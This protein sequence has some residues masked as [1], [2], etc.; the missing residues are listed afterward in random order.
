MLLEPRSCRRSRPSG[1]SVALLLVFALSFG[2]APR[3]AVA[4]AAPP[5]RDAAAPVTADELRAAVAAKDD[6]LL[7]SLV[8]RTRSPWTAVEGFVREGDAEV[9]RAVA[10]AYAGPDAEALRAHAAALQP[11]SAEDDAAVRAAWEALRAARSEA[12]VTSAIE[13]VKA[14]PEPARPTA[15]RIH[16]V[17]DVGDAQLRLDR[18]D[19]AMGTLSAAGENAEEIGWLRGAQNSFGGAAEAAI[20]WRN[21]DGAADAMKRYMVATRGLGVAA[22]IADGEVSLASALVLARR[23]DEARAFAEAGVAAHRALDPKSDGYAAAL[24]TAAGVHRAAGDYELALEGLATARGVFEELR[25]G[26]WVAHCWNEEGRVREDM[27]DRSGALDA[28]L[29]CVELARSRGDDRVLALALSNAVG[30]QRAIGN[31]TAAHELS[32]EALAAA[33]RSGDAQAI[34]AAHRVLGR[35]KT[36]IGAFSEAL[37]HLHEAE[38]HAAKLQFDTDVLDA[39]MATADTLARMGDA[40]G[41]REHLTATLPLAEAG[42][43]P[44]LAL[45]IRLR[46]ASVHVRLDRLAK[47]RTLYA[48]LLESELPPSSH[49]A[50]LLNAAGVHLRLGEADRG[51][52][53]MLEAVEDML[54]RDVAELHLAEARL[55][56]A[57]AEAEL[58]DREAAL[59]VAEGVVE[60]A[61]RVGADDLLVRGLSAAAEHALFTGD[62]ERAQRMAREA[63]Q[64]IMR[65]TAGLAEGEGGQARDLASAAFKVGLAAA[66]A[67][68]DMEGAVYF[69]EQGRAGSLREGLVGIDAATLSP[70]DLDA[71]ARA[72]AD[73]ERDEARI[74]RARASGSLKD[75]RAAMAAL[76]ESENALVRV[77]ARV[78][79]DRRRGAAVVLGDPDSL[80][81]IRARLAPGDAL[82][83]YAPGPVHWIALVIRAD[84]ASAVTLPSMEEV[85]SLATA[86]LREDRGV[87]PEAVEPLR[88]A[89]VEPLGL[90]EDVTR[91]LV[92]PSGTLAYLPFALLLPDVEVANTPSATTH[93]LLLED[94][95][96]R[97]DGVLGIGDPAYPS[98]QASSQRGTAGRDLARLPSTR[99]E[100]EAVA[101][102]RLVGDEATV[103]GFQAAVG[104]RER[105]R[106]VHFACHGLVDGRRPGLSSLALTPGPDGDGFLTALEIFRL[107]IPADVVVLSACETAKG[108]VYLTEG[109]VGM[110]RAFMFAGSPRVLCSLWKVDDAATSA[111]MT[112]LYEEWGEGEKGVSLAAA[113]RRAQAR[114]RDDPD[115]PEWKH[116]DYW[117]AWV[118]WGLAD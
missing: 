38:A 113:L 117:A 13:A 25:Q 22:D 59:A 61:G 96:L 110:T 2:A 75:V 50:T 80:D 106:S 82:V 54:A 103:A 102:V 66:V 7:K 48:E 98:R 73:V 14:L 8:Q 52:A 6:E 27:S 109:V 5:A 39:R 34:A 1:L 45:S 36:S 11:T 83:A 111:L 32:R 114:V 9:A 26:Y 107:R 3:N 24:M 79:R 64:R 65:H 60:V 55:A 70:E 46:I 44:Q 42:R 29:R 28:Y 74:R 57:G 100:V 20:A 105:W 15:R 116:P 85:D 4:Q 81:S 33:E 21:F 18:F 115:H 94:A 101:D 23:P 63:V 41:A 86:L 93:G 62:L 58:G 97:G 91:V 99:A 69:L 17:N 16:L 47:A 118:L 89:I 31:P 84:G 49:A 104:K 35:T 19:E 108:R 92:S 87:D 12:D 112:A 10:A 90:G 67:R 51:R 40:E 56:L 76:E 78:D 30:A 53:M 71:L 88:A 68:S 95:P 77:S 72:R 37:H 43:R